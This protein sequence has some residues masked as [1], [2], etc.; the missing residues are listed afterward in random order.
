MKITLV[1]GFVSNSTDIR[2]IGSCLALFPF[3]IPE[4][5]RERNENIIHHASCLI[6]GPWNLG[7]KGGHKITSERPEYQVR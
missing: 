4:I 6:L 1:A 7:R 3:Q 5:D 2:H